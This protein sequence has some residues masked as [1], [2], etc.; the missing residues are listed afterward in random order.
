M[1]LN[2]V[3]SDFLLYVA[4]LFFMYGTTVF[5]LY[6][7]DV[8]EKRWYQGR[9]GMKRMLLHGLVL[10]PIALLWAIYGPSF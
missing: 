6:G 4:L 3:G 1:T 9:A 8:G 10:L 5:A 2:H 7:L